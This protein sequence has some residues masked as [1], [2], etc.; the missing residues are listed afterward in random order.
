MLRALV[1]SVLLGVSSCASAGGVD[2]DV[3]LAF[4]PLGRVDAEEVLAAVEREV[5]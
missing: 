1:F 3:S 5:T 2:P 4:A